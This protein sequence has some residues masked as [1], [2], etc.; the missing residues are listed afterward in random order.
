MY[1]Y[2]QQYPMLYNAMTPAI[3]YALGRQ[4]LRPVTTTTKKVTTPVVVNRDSLISTLAGATN[5]YK[6]ALEDA[7]TF[8]GKLGKSVSDQQVRDALAAPTNKGRLESKMG[9][10]QALSGALLSGLN[11]YGKFEAA[12]ENKAAKDYEAALKQLTMEDSL[13]ARKEA[14][15]LQNAI[16][17]QTTVTVEDM[18]KTTNGKAG[19]AD[20]A[21]LEMLQNAIALDAMRSNLED[22]GTRFDS[23]FKN[24]DEMQKGSTRFGRWR[25][26]ALWGVG[27][28]DNEKQAREDFEAWKGSMKN[29]LVNANRQA[30]TGAMSDADAA[31]FEQRIGEAKNPAEA[32]NILDSFQARI[33]QT[34]VQNLRK[35]Y[36]QPKTAEENSESSL[37][38]Y[39]KAIGFDP[40]TLSADPNT[41]RAAPNMLR[42]DPN[43]LSADPEINPERGVN[44]GGG[45]RA[46]AQGL[47]VVGSYADEAEAGIRAAWD[48]LVQET[49]YQ[50][51]HRN[52]PKPTLQTPGTAGRIQNFLDTRKRY[53]EVYD[54]S[55]DKYLK[56][57]RESY[58]G[59]KRNMPEIAYPLEIGTG[60]VGEA[61]LAALT[62]GASL[63]PAV[64]G[65]MGAVYGYGMGERDVANRALSAG[66]IGTASAALPVAGKYAV[67]GGK[68][69]VNK[70]VNALA[71]RDMPALM[72]ALQKDTV[73][74]KAILNT[75]KQPSV[76]A[77]LTGLEALKKEA[78]TYADQNLLENIIRSVRNGEALDKII[79]DNALNYNGDFARKA[80]K[81]LNANSISVPRLNV[82]RTSINKGESLG[83]KIAVA[84]DLIKNSTKKESLY[85]VVS[86]DVRDV[87]NKDW[88]TQLGEGIVDVARNHGLEGTNMQGLLNRLLVATSDGVDTAIKDTA[89]DVITTALKDNIRNTLTK[90]TKLPVAFINELEDRVMSEVL[91]RR[92]ANTLVG[93]PLENA[94]SGL[95]KSLAT[96]ITLGIAGNALAGPVG[97]IT[98]A[99]MRNVLPGGNSTFTKA[100]EKIIN[101][102]ADKGIEKAVKEGNAF[103]SITKAL[104]GNRNVKP[105]VKMT[106]EEIKDKVRKD[107]SKA[108]IEILK[109]GY[110]TTKQLV[111]EAPKKPAKQL[112]KEAMK[113]T[114][115]AA[116]PVGIREVLKE[117]DEYE[118]FTGKQER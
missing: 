55:Y 81:V 43:T 78:K 88:K 103:T 46:A 39:N 5:E 20:T 75:D 2:T 16:N 89:D 63:H 64:Q 21:G 34:P 94:S 80:A 57:A 13:M 40:N 60:I 45:V 71:E 11:T 47:P 15:D 12:E 17:N 29:V 107:A 72:K 102:A 24:I 84:N 9:W 10:G 77:A 28:T 67:K 100:G 37:K 101:K 96:D 73:I 68:A 79:K 35:F 25:T 85:K 8:W 54:K 115:K 65:A 48:A 18:K 58:E 98:G 56:N 117:A 52:D 111:K 23:S 26:D 6:Q 30:G 14:A 42:V 104:I 86:S 83:D 22:I 41:L 3:A 19:K 87:L 95:L 53:N 116:I 110:P 31:R 66:I 74:G 105:L 99:L 27:R 33:M 97:G 50:Q 108:I 69:V 91:S 62:G 82:L 51:E 92:T 109:S 4:E 76:E 36:S 106:A 61:G 70:T 90:E 44:F 112:V 118:P 114:P 49:M 38:D 7:N 32:R 113:A 59:A 1:E 93:K